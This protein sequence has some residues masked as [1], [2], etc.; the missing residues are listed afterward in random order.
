LIK[1][2]PLEIISFFS[3][4]QSIKSNKVTH[5]IANHLKMSSQRMTFDAAFVATTEDPKVAVD[6]PARTPR[7][8]DDPV[9]HAV[10]HTPPDD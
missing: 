10:L 6:A 7:I 9:G 4:N 8:L 1:T 5:Y 3:I 2:N